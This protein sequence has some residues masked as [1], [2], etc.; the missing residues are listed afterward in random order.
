MLE[1]LLPRRL[2]NDYRGRRVALWLFAIVLFVKTGI[3]LST[4]FNGRVAAESADGIPLASFGPA[5]A[6]TVLALFAIWGVA[7]LVISAIGV[8][9]L[10]R[11][12]AMVPLMFLLLTLEYLAKKVVLLALPIART[13]PAPG[14]PINV[15]LLALMI[16]GL[17]LSLWPRK[18]AAVGARR[19]LTISA[20]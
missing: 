15:A 12:R 7:Y 10:V 3:A 17:A 18:G 16:A 8:L 5:A 6:D 14:A 13:G 20:R 19:K 4:I 2:D 9:A 1:R 11:Y